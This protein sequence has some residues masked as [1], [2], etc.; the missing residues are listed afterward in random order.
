VRATTF[1]VDGVRPLCKKSALRLAIVATDMCVGL[2]CNYGVRGR[3]AHNEESGFQH[4]ASLVA[5][6]DR[7]G[8]APRAMTKIT[9]DI[10]D[11][12]VCHMLVTKASVVGSRWLLAS[13][14]KG[15][16]VCGRNSGDHAWAVS[17]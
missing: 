10:V 11:K 3:N 16:L 13:R 17:P 7:V 5:H 6:I 1:H 2:N 15:R 12:H 14:K 4:R 8:S 9:T